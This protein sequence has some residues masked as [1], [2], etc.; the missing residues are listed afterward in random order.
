MR[1]S[2]N[3]FDVNCNF[4]SGAT[5]P[6]DFPVV[7]D[8]LSHM[9]RLEINY[10]LVWHTGAR[11]Y[12][13]TWGNRKMLDEISENSKASTRLFPAFTIVPS[14]IYEKGA[15]RFLKQAMTSGNVKALRYFTN[16]SRFIH[17][18]PVIRQVR[19]F[20]PVLLLDARH[21]PDVSEIID[22]TDKFPEIPIIYTQGM[23]GDVSTMFDLMRRSENVYID[24]SWLHSRGAIE[25]AVKH[26]GAERVLFGTGTRA[27]N[28][29]SISALNHADLTQG[30]R[31]LIAGKNL[32]RLLGIDDVQLQEISIEDVDR[33]HNKLWQ[34]VRNGG[35]VDEEVIDAHG[36]FGAF[37]K[38]VIEDRKFEEQI[39]DVIH[40]MDKLGI[41]KI[42]VSSE[43]AYKT[44]PVAGHRYLKDC[45]RDYKERILGYLAFNPHYRDQLSPL[46]D[47]FFADSFFVGFKIHGDTW[48]VPVNDP[49]FDTVYKYADSH[50]LP[51]LLHTWGTNYSSPAMLTDIAKN[52]PHAYFLL[53]HSGGGNKGRREAVTLVQN[54]SN[55]Y[56]E[57]CG[58]FTSN[59][60]WEDT[61]FQVGNDNIIFG[62]DTSLHDPAW[63]LGRFLSL[64]VA[65]EV[66][67]PILASNIKKILAKQT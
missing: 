15:I 43:H 2:L 49:R 20:K 32:E 61:I 50:N 51:I 1:S 41:D 11:D 21:A 42:I 5:S 10:G 12:N 38:A 59:I 57:W 30:E 54:N 52:H 65:D 9:N 48:Q 28:G 46:L 35:G 7:N 58:S 31:E 19:K 27:H 33:S 17:I 40:R 26:F 63:E 53:G 18:D 16:Y 25:M 23:W 36:H 45:V 67:R 60:L 4:G 47:E 22:F 34:K 66:L 44:D 8:L 37:D 13:T 3:L 64:D 39:P 55:V 56:L 14:M 6:P 24:T 62:T 29:A